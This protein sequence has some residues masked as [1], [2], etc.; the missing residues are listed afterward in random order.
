MSRNVVVLFAEG[1][2]NDLDDKKGGYMIFCSRFGML[3]TMGVIFEGVYTR[4]FTVCHFDPETAIIVGFVSYGHFRKQKKLSTIF[5]LKVF[6]R[7]R[8]PKAL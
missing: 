2:N 5:F 6:D 8:K 7:N 4:G 3:C 1:Y